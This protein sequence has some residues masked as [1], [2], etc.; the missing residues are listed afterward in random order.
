VNA[1]LLLVVLF[2]MIAA[3]ASAQTSEPPSVMSFRM[4][5]VVLYPSIALTNLGVD[6]NVFNEPDQVTPKSDFTVTLTPA[7]EVRM[8]LGRSQLT[9]S[10]KEDLVYYRKY[11]SERSVNSRATVGFVAPLRRLT[12]KVGAGHLGTRERPGFEIDV[13]SQ[14][15][16]TTANGSV[17]IRALPKIFV[18]LR[19]DRTRVNYDKSAIFLDSNLHFE[20][21]RT[22]TAGALTARYR[23][24]PL[25]SLTFD[26]GLGHDRFEFS[27]LRDSDST[28]IEGGVSFEQRALLK[29]SA[30]FGYRHFRPLSPETAPYKGSVAS[31]NLTYVALGSTK[32]GVEID[33]D[34]QYSYELNQPFYVQTGLIGSVTRHLF[35]PIDLTGRLG[36]ARLAYQN[37]IVAGPPLPARTDSMRSYGGGLGYRVARRMRI[38]LNVDTYRRTSSV[39]LRQYRGLTFGTSVTYG[40]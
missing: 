38:G 26:A 37:R 17:E 28:R 32:I 12:L 36:V 29:G 11:E 9:G 33:R 40:S 27:P 21:N 7:T 25:T 18:G 6:S 20:L 15:Y 8:R 34:V 31:V 5:P 19:G 14:R 35:G 23:L 3:H 39:A 22:M 13:R 16:E 10:I 4:G 2:G 1:T 30:S 24:T